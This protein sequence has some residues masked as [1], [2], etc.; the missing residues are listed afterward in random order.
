VGKL[1]SLG[2]IKVP[3]GFRFSGAEGTR[4]FLELTQNPP[5]GSELG[6]LVPVLEE[7]EN[8]DNFWFVI[9]EFHDIGYVKDVILSFGLESGWSGSGRGKEKRR[10][11]KRRYQEG[12]LTR[13]EAHHCFSFDAEVWR[14]HILVLSR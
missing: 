12:H 6:V 2:Q 5:N 13:M 11:N 4:K 9:F 10:R 1:G 14:S 7:N 8:T 3:A